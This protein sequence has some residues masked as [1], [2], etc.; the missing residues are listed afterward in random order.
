MRVA[1]S[2]DAWLDLEPS[3][4]GAGEAERL[5]GAVRGELVWEQRE[6]VLYGK[7]IMQPRLIAWCGEL[8]YRYSG[9]T[10]APRPPTPAVAALLGRVS[11]HA[12]E[13]FNHVL[14]NRY[15]DGRDSMG[16]HADDEPELGA[17]P[18]VATLS[19]GTARRFV[20]VPRRPRDRERAREGGLRP[21]ELIAGGAGPSEGPAPDRRVVELAG[22]SLAVMGGAFQRRFRHGLP[23]DP[24]V[25][26]ERISLTFR[27]V[28]RAPG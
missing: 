15:R 5:L 1:L 11:A 2:P 3:W 8:P 19:L 17:D 23:R 10:L 13:A 9:Q 12:G 28:E 27:R 22:G 16:L 21:P 25:G 14:A 26:G 4:L 24:H 7:R 20:I 18:V 6:I